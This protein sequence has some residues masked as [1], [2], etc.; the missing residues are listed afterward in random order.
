MKIRTVITLWAVA[1]V[2]GLAVFF[3]KQ[4]QAAADENVTERAA[5]EKLVADFP[6]TETASIEIMGAE[7]SVTLSLKDGKWTVANRDDF[8]ANTR[9]VN[10]FLR[11][12]SELKVTQCIEAGSSFAPRF[13]MDENSSDPAEHGITATF[14][15]KSGKDL[16]KISFGK[17]LDAA[18]SASP[19]GGGATGRYVR[20]HADESGFYAVSEVFGILSTDPKSWLADDFIKVERIKS[21]SLSKPSSDEHEFALIRDDENADFKFTD[22]FPGVNI[23]PAAVNPLKSLFSYA[24]FDDLVPAA[25]VAAR[26]TPEKLQ[27]ASIATF[28][29]FTYDITLQPVKV[30]AAKEGEDAAPAAEEYLMEIKVS[31]ELPKERKKPETETP[32]DAETADKAFA[33][34]LKTLTKRLEEAKALEGRTFLVSKFTVAALLKGRA[35][36]MSKGPGPG[37]RAPTLPPGTSVFTPPVQIPANPSPE[38]VK[39]PDEGQPAP[40]P[41]LPEKE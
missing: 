5:G 28:E 27:K 39:K 34:R 26:A 1:I 35:E 21:I 6:A 31:A 11:T 22:A 30:A 23:D 7:Q 38:D 20:N 10:D 32:E 3:L 16:A 12:L 41:E 36:L 25:E 37:S 8:P 29:G 19:Y 14:K 24:R 40:E 15:D 2:L 9:N 4:Y 13:G 33:E 18:A 17:N